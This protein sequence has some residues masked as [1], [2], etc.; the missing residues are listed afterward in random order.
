MDVGVSGCLRYT[1]VREVVS[2]L[3]AKP[4]SVA[5]LLFFCCTAST[6]PTARAAVVSAGAGPVVG[7]HVKPL[8]ERLRA[9]QPSTS[10][11][12]DQS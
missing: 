12:K 8:T 6:A 7:S 9:A 10:H 5:Q 2:F 1:L 11:L 4:E 3:L